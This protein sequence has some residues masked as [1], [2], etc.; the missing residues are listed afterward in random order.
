MFYLASTYPSIFYF[1]FR[2]MQLLFMQ[3][4]GGNLVLGDG[5]VPRQVQKITYLNMLISENS[6]K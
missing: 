6:P 1:I 5:H 4:L 3:L 2:K